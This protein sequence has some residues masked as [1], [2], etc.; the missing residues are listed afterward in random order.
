MK[1]GFFQFS[2]V[3]GDK[4]VNLDVIENVVATESADLVI[5][6][7]LSNSGYLFLSQQEVAQL[8]EPIPGP[9]TEWLQS[10]AQDSGTHFIMGMPEDS[11]GKYY[12]SAVLVGPGGVVGTYRKAHLFYEE[13]LYFQPGE[14]Q[15]E[16]FDV[17]GVKIGILICFDHLFPE[18]ARVLALQGAQIICYPSNLVLPTYGQLTTR[19]RAIENQVFTILSNRCGTEDRGQ[20]S[21][22]YTGS[23]QMAAPNGEV[24]ASATAAEQAL[25]IVDINPE[26]ALD[27]SVTERNDLFKDRRPELYSSLSL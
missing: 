11:D 16:I 8:A 1:I 24:L 20:K 4:A 21:L 27:K 26:D 3:F 23:S 10:L 13:K 18:A 2:P 25:R 12:N 14:N 19:T 22:T 6:P 17:G 7:E 9:T 5:I 15:F